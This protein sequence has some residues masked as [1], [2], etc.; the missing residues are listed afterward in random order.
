MRKYIF[1]ERWQAVGTPQAGFSNGMMAGQMEIHT[2]VIDHFMQRLQETGV[3]DERSRSGSSPQ[4]YT[5][6]RSAN[7]PVC[8]QKL[9]CYIR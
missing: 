6:I 1:V 4:D 5:Q 8:Q 7:I 2:S 9:F 3:F